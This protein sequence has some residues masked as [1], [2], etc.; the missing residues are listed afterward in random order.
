MICGGRRWLAGNQDGR[1]IGTRAGTVVRRAFVQ[2][3]A[4]CADE[5]LFRPWCL[6]PRVPLAN[7]T[8]LFGTKGI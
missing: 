1:E 3:E 8:R 5:P 7:D 4:R 6:A 2:R